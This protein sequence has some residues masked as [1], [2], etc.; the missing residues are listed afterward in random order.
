[1][2]QKTVCGL[3]IGKAKSAE[4][5]EKLAR[6][7]ENCPYVAFIGA[8]DDQ[9]VWACFI[10]EKHLWWMEAIRDKPEETLGLKSA[11]L[12][13]TDEVKVTYPEEFKLRLPQEKLNVAPC[14]T[15]CKECP[16]FE[17]CSG[18]PATIYY[19]GGNY[20]DNVRFQTGSWARY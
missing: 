11:T 15:D 17:R 14:G 5:A 7:F 2:K 1:M 9:F 4:G 6:A 12:L 10:P 19:K 16:S 20:L 8:F 18:C 13:T 3:L